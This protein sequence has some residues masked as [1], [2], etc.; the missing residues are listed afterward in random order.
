MKIKTKNIS[1]AQA[2]NKKIPKQKIKKPNWLFSLLVRI[3]SIG[4]LNKAKFT[5]NKS[6]KKFFK[7]PCLILMNHSCFLDLKIASKIIFPKRHF[8]VSTT[9]AF[10]GKNWLMRQI[11]CIPTQKFTTTLSLINDMNYCLNTLKTSVLLYPEAGYSFD[12]RTTEIPKR[13]GVLVKKLNVPLVSIITDGAFNY[14]PLFNNLRFRKSKV[15][16][17]VKYLATKEEVKQL[18]AQEISQLIIKEFSFDAFK[19]QLENKVIINEDNRAEGIERILYKCPHCFSEGT[20]KG[21]KAKITCSKCGAT[22]LLT[23]LGELKGE[24]VETKF[25]KVTDWYDFERQCAK[26]EILDGKVNIEL[27]VDLKI[28]A[29]YKALYSV[30]SGKLVQNENGLTL[31]DETGNELFFQSATS[32]YSLNVDF[33]WYEIGDVI[34]IG[35]TERLYYCFP[36]TNFPVAKSRLIA[37]ELYK[38]KTQQN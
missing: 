27:D 36:K 13:L 30:G 23:E 18:S 33:F 26:Q 5:F 17:E 31:F 22:Y 28:I 37:E 24:N 16:A 7:E 12:G 3:L 35:N 34:C 6:A 20:I 8:I 15:T 29:D 1:L 32:T 9:D 25:N 10:V 14:Q 19:S 2:L 11:G 4:E 21:E 38:I